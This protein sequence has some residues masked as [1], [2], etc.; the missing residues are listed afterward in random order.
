MLD[1]LRAERLR[2]DVRRRRERRIDVPVAHGRDRQQVA[3]LVHRRRIRRERLERI[4]HRLEH[5]VLDRHE[6]GGL[7]GRVARLRRHRR[8]HV[9]HTAG[10]LPLGHE[11]RPVGRDQSL[12]PLA[13]H[14]RGRRDPHHAGNGLRPAGVDVPHPGARMVGEAKRGMQHA[15]DGHVADEQVLPED[16]P[17]A[18][19]FRRGGTHAVGRSRRAVDDPRARGRR[20][21]LSAGRRRGGDQSARGTRGGP[22]LDPVS[23]T[24]GGRPA[25]RVDHLDVA[26]ASAQV[27]GKRPGDL[28]ARRVWRTAEQRLGLH[29]DAGGAVAALDRAGRRERVHPR[30]TDLGREPLEGDHVPALDATGV[31]CAGDDRPAVDEHR[32]RPARS[33][34]RATVLRGAQAE[35]LAEHLEEGLPRPNLRR[36]APPVE[37]ELHPTPLSLRRATASQSSDPP[38]G[39]RVLFGPTSSCRRTVSAR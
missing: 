7:A 15:R 11:G 19:A 17:A 14:V 2:H 34:R 36:D 24:L 33:L 27:A 4:R 37:R 16:E 23:T 22:G 3:A 20:G 9:A 12:V 13:G 30:V 18:G 21:V 29:H 8:E 10:R 39:G 35:P 1:R 5:V 28:L 32:A 26:G 25:H 6:R 31:L 38:A